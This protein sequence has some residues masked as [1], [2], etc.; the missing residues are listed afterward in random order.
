MADYGKISRAAMTGIADAIRAK[1]DTTAVLTPAQMAVEINGIVTGDNLP[2][3]EDA[4]FGT[5][6]SVETGYTTSQEFKSSNAISNN[7]SYTSTHGY[8]F[9]VN[10]PISFV[11]FRFLNGDKGSSST[12]FTLW[13][14]ETNQ[15]IAKLTK[16]P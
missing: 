3:A 9:S 10:A 6:S 13:D 12:V 4:Y 11:G 7:I 2:N 16:T 8:K 15:E 14:A 1:K 5:T